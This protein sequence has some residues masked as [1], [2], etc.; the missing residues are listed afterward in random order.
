VFIEIL[1]TQ[2]AMLSDSE[3]VITGKD[4][5]R[6][7][8]KSVRLEGVQYPADL[9]IHLGD[10][11]VIRGDLFTDHLRSERPWQQLFIPNIQIS[12]IKWMP[13]QEVGRKGD[14]FRLLKSSR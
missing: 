2:Q 4:D 7:V 9:C 3:S 13:G 11:A 10:H 1:L 6:I 8:Q 12:I 5:D 14:L